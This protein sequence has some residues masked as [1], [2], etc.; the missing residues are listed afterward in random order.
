V[1]DA[2]LRPRTLVVACAGVVALTACISML[3]LDNDK[4]VSVEEQVCLQYATLCTER[5]EPYAFPR[6]KDSCRQELATAFQKPGSDPS[7]PNVDAYASNHCRSKTTCVD[8]LDCLARS[9]FILAP[10]TCAKSD[11]LAGPGDASVPWRCCEN[12]QCIELDKV[13]GCL[14]KSKWDCVGKVVFPKPDML[15]AGQ[16]DLVASFADINNA[17]V[18]MDLT[19]RVCSR[20]DPDCLSPVFT[21][22]GNGMG[23]HTLTMPYAFDGYIEATYKA[24]GDGGMNLDYLP[25][26]V[27]VIPPIT[28]ENAKL[29]QMGT[30]PMFRRAAYNAIVGSIGESVNPAMGHVFISARDCQFLEAPNTTGTLDVDA[31]RLMYFAGMQPAPTR[32][33]TDIGGQIG[34]INVPPGLRQTTLRVRGVRTGT[35]NVVVRAG[36]L[37]FLYLPPTP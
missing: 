14:D 5:A 29:M 34:V 24:P 6:D 36:H 31:G 2:L 4:Y 9:S 19:V 20:L 22:T 17:Q 27:M 7:R 21:S 11:C 8:Y 37:S 26:L 23:V 3:G 10:S 32:T 16:V 13:S 15:D 25:L 28:A 12:E 35:A 1:G 18:V 30:I 33:E